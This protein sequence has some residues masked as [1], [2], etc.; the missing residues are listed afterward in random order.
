MYYV[1][2]GLLLAF[3][4]PAWALMGPGTDWFDLVRR[5]L[6]GVLFAFLFAGKPPCSPLLFRRE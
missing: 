1:R 4:V 3:M 6:V 2:L 5:G